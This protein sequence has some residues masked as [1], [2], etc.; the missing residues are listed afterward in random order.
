[1]T[2][3]EAD[4]YRDFDLEIESRHKTLRTSEYA[5]E[6]DIHSEEEQESDEAYRTRGTERISRKRHGEVHDDYTGVHCGC[7]SQ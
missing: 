6:D 3:T 2:M 5:G 4:T 1:M 7:S